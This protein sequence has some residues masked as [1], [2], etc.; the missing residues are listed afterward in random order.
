[1]RGLWCLIP[2]CASI[3]PTLAGE[4]DVIKVV[5]EEEVGG[6]W[7]FQV[8]VRHA[9]Q[10]WDHYADRWDVVAPDGSL[11]GTRT[12]LHPHVDEQPFTRS[13]SGVEIPLDVTS[14]TIRAGDSVH[15]YGGHEMVVELP[16]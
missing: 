1:M 13:L 9:D 4:A 5:A 2:L 7:R 3:G 6:T 15:K 11:L 16:R 10:G 8:T 14:V 12:L